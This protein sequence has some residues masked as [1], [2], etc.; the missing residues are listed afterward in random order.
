[1]LRL[2]LF[3]FGVLGFSGLAL[4]GDDLPEVAAALKIMQEMSSEAQVSKITEL[5]EKYPTLTM[6]P[7]SEKTYR[8]GWRVLHYAITRG[9]KAVVEVLVEKGEKVDLRVK[10]TAGLEPL[11]I[12]IRF[13]NSLSGFSTSSLPHTDIIAY[14]L[15]KDISLLESS[16]KD[17]RSNQN[18]NI[19]LFCLKTNS[20]YETQKLE[21][22]DWLFD[23]YLAKVGRYVFMCI[24][25]S[26]N[27]LSFLGEL[28]SASS[29][30][31]EQ[32]V[33][34][35]MDKIEEKLGVPDVAVFNCKIASPTEGPV[36]LSEYAQTYVKGD[37]AKKFNEW[38]DKSVQRQKNLQDLTQSLA[39]L[40]K[41]M[42]G[43]KK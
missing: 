31:A 27:P 19:L 41:G 6:A 40:S 12:A 39:E 34:D 5:V 20:L 2:F 22:I 14:L 11:H 8:G 30:L 13:A 15:D 38:F 21:I 28:I 3:C 29:S 43:L 9:V 16:V 24:D 23:F 42:K 7:I 10:T 33:L 26:D 37:I 35:L 17:E 32:T 18:L 36:T 25:D 4:C 1:M